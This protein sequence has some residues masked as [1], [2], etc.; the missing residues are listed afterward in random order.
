LIFSLAEF[1][2]KGY[3]ELVRR[4]WTWGSGI[5]L[6][7]GCPNV[8]DD[9]VQHRIV[10][11]DS[12]M[13]HVILQLVE[14]LGYDIPIGVKLSPY[15][16]PGLLKEVAAVIAGARRDDGRPVVSYVAVTN[17]FPNGLGY[18]PA[19]KSALSTKEA[20]AVGGIGGEALKPISLSNAAQFRVALPDDIAVIRVGGVSSGE[21]L[22]Q[23]YD[24]GAIGVQMATAVAK[25]GPGV[26]RAVR[27][28]Y[29]DIIG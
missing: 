5:E 10:S 4:T 8:R 9:G 15:S 28:E 6:N 26:F 7:F 19:R 29:A 1:S 11:F 21:D 17:T 27:Q 24:V 20:G 16:D 3:E 12:S 22:W 2:P 25:Q 23:S 18:T 14:L 13:I